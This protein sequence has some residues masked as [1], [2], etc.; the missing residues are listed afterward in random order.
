MRALPGAVSSHVVGTDAAKTPAIGS[1]PLAL[2]AF[3][4]GGEQTA[5]SAP[6]NGNTAVTT[7]A[8]PSFAAGGSDVVEAVNSAVFVYSRAGAPVISFGINGMIGNAASS[9]YVVQYPHVVYDP[10]SG[11]F[12]LMVLESNVSACSSQIV[13][14]DSQTNP[15]LPWQARG[16][17]SLNPALSGVILANLSMALTGTLVVASSDYRACTGSGVLG[18]FVA[19]QTILLQ[20]ADLV[21]GTETT[22]SGHFLA[23]GPIGA[24]PVMGLGLSSVAYEIANDVNCTN[25]NA[26]PGTYVVFAITGTPDAGNVSQTCTA[27]SRDRDECAAGCATERH[28]YNAVNERRSV[29]QR[30]VVQQHA[31]RSWGDCM[32][33]RRRL[34]K[35]VHASTSSP[36]PRALPA[37]SPR[38]PSSRS[39]VWSVHICTTRR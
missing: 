1:T 16:S 19:S 32:H 6:G 29:S 35:R 21:A 27:E 24:Q 7:P 33:A 5:I 14:M 18:A 2:T 20:R 3:E 38:R 13:V 28:R 9:G 26:T 10:V 17:V 22:H 15:A 12:I 31:H 4:G 36:S 39:R 8:D 34:R 37:P 11:V 25:T 23:P 30:D